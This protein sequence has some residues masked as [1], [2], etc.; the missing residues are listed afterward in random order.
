MG[1]RASPRE[2]GVGGRAH[3]SALPDSSSCV[4][5]LAF[6][7]IALSR[8]WPVCYRAEISVDGAVME[9]LPLRIFVAAFNRARRGL[10]E[11]P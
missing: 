2:R 9:V 7:F 5:R 8:L 3:S 1:L 10:W 6:F 11:P 4:V